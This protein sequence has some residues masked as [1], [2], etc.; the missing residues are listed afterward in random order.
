MVQVRSSLGSLEEQVLRVL[1]EGPCS[2][3]ECVLELARYGGAPAEQE[4]E[5]AALLAELA[6]YAYLEC[7]ANGRYALTPAGSIRLATLVE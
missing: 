4:R 3:Q 2:A 5:V 7:R 6:E 1:Y